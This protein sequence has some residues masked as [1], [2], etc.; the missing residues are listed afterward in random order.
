MGT[1]NTRCRHTPRIVKLQFLVELYMSDGSSVRIGQFLGLYLVTI[2]IEQYC[3]LE[4]L[5][6]IPTTI[7]EKY[8]SQ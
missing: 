7:N 1:Y 5:V 2:L 3:K 4:G 8:F 6:F